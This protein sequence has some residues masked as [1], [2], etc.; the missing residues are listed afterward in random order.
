MSRFKLKT[1]QP[2]EIMIQAAILE[3]LTYEI[4]LGRVVWANRMNSG[5]TKYF[6][7]K[8]GKERFIRFGF[9]GCPDIIGQLSDGR[10]LYLECKTAEGRA[11]DHQ[12]A[13]MDKALKHGAV[14]GIVRSADEAVDIVRGAFK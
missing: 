8:T 7:E 11:T 6:D 13:F 14:G 9:P 10:A 3:A 4:G 12:K 5:A 1:W 2:T